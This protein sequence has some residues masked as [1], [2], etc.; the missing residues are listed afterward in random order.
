MGNIV[1]CEQVI[2]EIATSSKI[3]DG[4]NEKWIV[5][6]HRDVATWNDVYNL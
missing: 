5:N 1:G 6:S 2:L 3:G 4:Q